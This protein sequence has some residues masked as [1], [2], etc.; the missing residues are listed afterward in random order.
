MIVRCGFKASSKPINLQSFHPNLGSIHL[1]KQKLKKEYNLH[2][3]PK[4]W[5]SLWTKEFEVALFHF[6]HPLTENKILPNI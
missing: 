3:A 6:K 1:M 4:E 5:S 2:Y